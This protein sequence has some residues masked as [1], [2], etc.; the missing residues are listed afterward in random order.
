MLEAGHDAVVNAASVAGRGLALTIRWRFPH[1]YKDSVRACQEGLLRVGTVRATPP[2][3]HGDPWIVHVPTKR[4]WR[5]P[6]RLDDVA[7]GIEALE[8]SIRTHGW[9]SVGVLKPGCGLGGLEWPAVRA[10]LEGARAART[11]V[12]TLYGPTRWTGSRKEAGM[13]RHGKKEDK[14]RRE[15]HG[16]RDNERTDHRHRH[17]D[18]RSRT[19]GPGHRNVRRGSGPERAG[20]AHG[21]AG[22]AG[23]AD[24][25]HRGRRDGNAPHHGGIRGGRRS[26]R[27]DEAGRENGLRGAQRGVRPG[28]QWAWGTRLVGAGRWV[29]TAGMAA[30][31]ANVV[32]MERGWSQGPCIAAGIAT[33]GATAMATGQVVRLI[34]H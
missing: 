10:V 22:H 9:K 18:D 6:S 4:H 25:S 11:C 7:K 3:S 5:N 30:T 20:Q 32:F 33:V 17:G 16:G 2:A 15:R 28:T 31:V 27:R 13:E 1:E 21:P 29:Y 8:E 24:H 23:A 14:T 26:E 34:A 12:I 19:A